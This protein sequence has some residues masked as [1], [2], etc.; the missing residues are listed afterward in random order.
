MKRKYENK[1]NE[2][3]KRFTEDQIKEIL[4][5]EDRGDSCKLLSVSKGIYY[6]LLKYF[7]LPTKVGQRR[8][9]VLKYT[10]EQLIELYK[11]YNGNIIR[12]IEEEKIERGW[13]VRIRLEELGYIGKGNTESRPSWCKGKTKETDPRLKKISERLKGKPF[14]YQ[15]PPWNTGLRKDT[16]ERLRNL[17]KKLKNGYASGEIKHWCKG[18]TKDT[19][20]ILKK[21]SENRK[22]G[23][24]EGRIK[25]WTKGLS[26]ETDPRIQ[27][28]AE[29]L[30]EG[31]RT[32]R[33]SN[34]NAIL[35]QAFNKTPS[36]EK[37]VMKILKELNIK[38]DHQKPMG[39]LIPDFVIEDKKIV[40]QVQGCFWHRCQICSKKVFSKNE[41]YEQRLREIKQVKFFSKRGYRT[42]F[43]W[44]HE[45]KNLEEVKSKILRFLKL[46][47]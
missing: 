9:T 23:I 39:K 37:R 29:K 12:L 5:K 44:E 27:K 43:I 17:S 14:P 35:V 33:F 42:L 11:K 30:K 21:L 2:V 47:K 22:K 7:N 13:T 1:Y 15:G 16:D 32:G 20:P 34:V 46:L 6:K 18:K 45:L 25:I 31:Y 28:M 4:V 40:I 41:L 3:F 8:N 26:K 38:Y 10:D 19:D 36:T 24:Q